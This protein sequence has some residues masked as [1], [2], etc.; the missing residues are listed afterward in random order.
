MSDAR[1]QRHAL[2]RTLRTHRDAAA[3]HVTH[4]FLGRHPEWVERYGELAWV[5]GLEDARFHVDFL[6]GAVETGRPAA[7]GDYARWTMR[8]LGA[9]GIGPEFL[10]ENLA[11]LRDWFDAVLTAP[12]RALVHSCV[13]AAF[14][15]VRAD[16]GPAAEDAPGDALALERSMYLRAVLDGQR[17]A[18]VTIAL[19]AF[20]RGV[21][22]TD[23]YCDLLQPT[24][25]EVGRLWECNEITVAR[26]HMATAITQFVV[27]QLYAR[28]ALPTMERGRVIVTGVE[29]ELHQLGANMLAD[30]LEA[31]GWNVRFLGTQ[32]PH[33]DILRALEDHRPAV[34]GISATMLFNLPRVT[35]LVADA[36]SE[37]GSALRI[38][39]GGGAF[40]SAPEV[41]RDIGA[42]GFGHDLREGIALV[43]RLVPAG[44]D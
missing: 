37:F 17:Q 19:E 25:Y 7:F 12:D 4:E 34:L 35:D 1:S 31:D 14:D 36:R 43:N 9:R 33:R 32:L 44:G 23:L 13:A 8:V 42:D 27:A 10:V 3:D 41:L 30:V 40:R 24:Q 11:Q 28:A 5:R 29:G 26:E 21:T 16:S 38:V 15:A 6:A 2:A 22:L 20:A 18:A 39:V